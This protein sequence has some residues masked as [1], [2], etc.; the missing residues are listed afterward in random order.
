MSGSTVQDI[1]NV[2]DGVRKSGSGYIARCPAHDDRKPSFDIKEGWL[3]PVFT[4]RSGCSQDAIM[5]ALKALGVWGQSSLSE[6][7]K[8]AR[9][10][11]RE[12]QLH[13][14]YREEA[15]AEQDTAQRAA[16]AWAL[17]T[18]LT[19]QHPYLSAKGLDHSALRGMV[20]IVPEEF[21]YAPQK[22]RGNGNLLVIPLGTK[23]RLTS[24]Q[25]INEAGG[26]F[27]LKGRKPCDSRFQ[28]PRSN[29]GNT[30]WLVEGFATGVSLHEATGD[31]VMVCF[32]LHGLKAV[33]GSLAPQERSVARVMADDDW[34]SEGN[35][36]VTAAKEIEHRHGIPYSLPKFPDNYDRGPKE[37]D[38]NDAAMAHKTTTKNEVA[39]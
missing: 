23:G 11:Q 24:L 34:C 26:K 12:A 10:A 3:G 32:N 13:Q 1:I 6:A 36:G 18:D 30:L 29:D 27:F 22:A 20:G 4:C 28:I 21:L 17:A 37:S 2:L 38:F 7:E 5:N 15:E 33:A 39:A 16:E 31:A 14:R 35:P 25:L 9:E 19:Y 8:A